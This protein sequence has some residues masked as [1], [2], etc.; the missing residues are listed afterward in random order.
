METHIHTVVYSIGLNPKFEYRVTCLKPSSII[1]LLMTCPYFRRNTNEGL[2]YYIKRAN[3]SVITHNFPCCLLNEGERLRIVQYADTPALQSGI[4]SQSLHPKQAY[5]SMLIRTTGGLNVYS[6]CLM[7]YKR[8]NTNYRM[9]GVY[10]LKGESIATALKRDGRFIDLV[11]D[12]NCF[13][14]TEGCCYRTDISMPVDKYD[15]Y[16]ITICRYR[17]QRKNA[18]LIRPSRG[19]KRTA[20]PA[21]LEFSTP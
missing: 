10:A 8:L 5:V 21:K 12:S 15:G 14:E 13:L 18:C 3:W 1:D 9:A 19:R 7:K 20:I 6:K 16:R 11:T 4:P 2:F 17:A